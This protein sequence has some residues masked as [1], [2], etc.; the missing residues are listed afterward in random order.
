ME[1][2]R[3]GRRLN[4]TENKPARAGLFHPSEFSIEPACPRRGREPR[5]H[6]MAKIWLFRQA[7]P[8]VNRVHIFVD[9]GICA[10]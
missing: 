6:A 1:E 10:L 9:S 8:F 5:S 2:G 3:S 4:P 7:P